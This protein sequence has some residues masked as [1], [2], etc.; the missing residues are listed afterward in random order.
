[1]GSQEAL[2]RFESQT[3]WP[4]LVLSLLI[5]PLLIIPL[6]VDLS[7]STKTTIFTLDWILWACSPWSTGS[8]SISRR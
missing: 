1:M 6:V 2:D 5:I 8:G 4:M 3:A 7:P